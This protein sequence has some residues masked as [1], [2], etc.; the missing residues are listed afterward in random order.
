MCALRKRDPPGV[1]KPSPGG[2]AP[3]RGKTDPHANANDDTVNSAAFQPLSPP[4][5]HSSGRNGKVRPL[6][7]R[8]MNVDRTR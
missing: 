4:P 6:S 3:D 5:R 8:P 2:G 7:V 1:R